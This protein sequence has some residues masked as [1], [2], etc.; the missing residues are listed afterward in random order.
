MNRGDFAPP[1][2]ET[3]L[4]LENQLLMTEARLLRARA[5]GFDQEIESLQSGYNTRIKSLER[6]VRRLQSRIEQ[7]QELQRS[8]EE[9]KRDYEKMQQRYEQLQQA[10][11]DLK[12]VLR[13][14]RD[15]PFGFAISRLKGFKHLAQRYL[16]GG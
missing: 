5:A 3:T 4:S 9:L 1:P 12:W 11:R 16:D 10:E 6:E 13:R 8:Y 15:S 2:D 7:H 14:L